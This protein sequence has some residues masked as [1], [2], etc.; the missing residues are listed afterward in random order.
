M[1]PAWSVVKHPLLSEK[2]MKKKDAGVYTFAVDL[3]ANKAEIK[4][5]IE[6]IY[7]VKVEAVRTIVNKGKIKRARNFVMRGRRKDWKKAY[8]KL[9]PGFRLDII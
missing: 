4:H 6:Q 9:K 1:R 3:K 5:A 2:S 8:V 7:G